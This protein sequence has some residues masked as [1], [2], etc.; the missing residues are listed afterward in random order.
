[1][2]VEDR[3]FVSGERDVV[4]GKE[5]KI[6]ISG[7][8]LNAWIEHGRKSTIAMCTVGLNSRKQLTKMLNNTMWEQHMNVP[9]DHTTLIG[10]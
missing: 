2:D 6:R 3:V 10:Y 8:F 1:M 5:L 9:H 7:Q 4:G